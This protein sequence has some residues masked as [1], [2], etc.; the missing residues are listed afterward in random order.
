MAS[1]CNPYGEPL[2]QLSANTCSVALQPVPLDE[3]SFEWRS[4]Q[5]AATSGGTQPKYT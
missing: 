5:H 4:V 1:S 3:Q 2:L